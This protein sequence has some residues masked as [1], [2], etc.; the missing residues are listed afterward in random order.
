MF[1]V[2]LFRQL[3][4]SYYL[5]G[6]MLSRLVTAMGCHEIVNE[7]NANNSMSTMQAERVRVA[8]E[9]SLRRETYSRSPS[10]RRKLMHIR[11]L[12]ALEDLHVTEP[13]SPPPTYHEAVFEEGEEETRRESTSESEGSDQSSE[14]ES[15]EDDGSFD[16]WSSDEDIDEEGENDRALVSIVSYP[17]NGPLD[18]HHWAELISEATNKHESD[19]PVTAS[20]VE[21]EDFED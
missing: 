21:I 10:L 18:A 13:P 9:M 3:Q 7:S 2:R 8:A 15:D 5:F 6:V 12:S 19:A 11:I 17:K 16:E 4:L 14:P 1:L 20:V